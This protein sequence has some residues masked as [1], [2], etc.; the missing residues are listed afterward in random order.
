L[1]FSYGTHPVQLAEDPESWSDFARQWLREHQLPGAVA[2]LVAGPSIRNPGAN[3]R[4]EFL[5][6]GEKTENP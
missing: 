3:H 6:V 1:A 2:M 4:I 5:R